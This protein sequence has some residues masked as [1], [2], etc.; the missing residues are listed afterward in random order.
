MRRPRAKLRARSP[1][2]ILVS[3]KVSEDVPE[4][5]TVLREK[6]FEVVQVSVFI[7]FVTGCRYE[8]TDKKKCDDNDDE[9]GRVF[10]SAQESGAKRLCALVGV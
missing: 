1:S 7:F 6:M 10:E 2:I 3:V 9:D 4:N 5:H 8:E